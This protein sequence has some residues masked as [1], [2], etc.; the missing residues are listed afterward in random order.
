MRTVPRR[1]SIALLAAVSAVAAVVAAPSA[2]TAATGDIIVKYAAGADPQERAEARADADVVARDTLPLPRTEVVAPEAGTTVAE[3]IADLEHSPDVVYAEPDAPRSAFTTTS[4]DPDLGDQWALRNTGQQKIFSSTGWSFGTAGDD[5]NVLDAWDLATEA[6]PTI[7]VV[8]SGV[9]L[10]HPDLKANI[11]SGG[12]DFV[13]NDAT[14]Q[15]ENGHG[16]HVAGTIGAVGN[17]G[18]G[19]SGVA[20]KAHLLPVR[21]LNANGRGSVSTVLKGEEYAAA[22]GAKVVN[23]SLGGAAPSQPEY[24]A[25]R[26]ASSTLFVVAAGNAGANVDV[27]DSYPCA[28]DLPN[29]ICV[30]AT[31]G[32]DE[33]A[34]FSNYGASSVDIAAPGVDILSTYPQGMRTSERPGYEWMSGTSMA[35]PEVAGA[36]ALLLS[37]DVALTPWQV[38]AKLMAGADPVAD[39]K[40]KVASGGRLDVLGAMN[41]DAPPADGAPSAALTAPSA[42]TVVSTPVSTPVTTTPTTPT[43]TPVTTT[44]APT[45]PV[46]TAP[47]PSTTTTA[48]KAPADTT[49]PALTPALATRGAL[50]LLLAARLNA[51]VATSEG[52]TVRFELRLDGRTAKKLHLAKSSAKAVRIATGSATLTSA[53]TKAGTLT[54][55]SAAKRTLARVRSVKVTLRATA[56]DAAGNARTRSRTVTITR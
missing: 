10:N 40:G 12:Q 26:A 4:N 19:I 6:A 25:L 39:L 53:G 31:G 52:A 55:T 37:R 35:T 28:Y 8:D 7:A 43:T 14:P 41:A 36:A 38:R 16:T 47:K 45:T 42:R 1:S 29:V 18:V 33:L 2:A 44:P 24:D 50:K 49:A 56:T 13:D 48:P 27:T 11:V 51:S 21:V 17:N 22:A 5:I 23:L 30:A 15:D 9:D 46:A 54:L 20:W 32:R 3:A 34:D